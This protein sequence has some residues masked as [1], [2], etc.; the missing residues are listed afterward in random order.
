[1]K[2]YNKITAYTDG[3]SRGNPGPSAIGI[4]I[5][6]MGD[7]K[8]YCQSIGIATNNIAEYK[9]VIFALKKIRSLVGKNNLKDVEV[10]IKIDSELVVKQLNAE[11]RV[12]NEDMKVLFMD[13]W[14]LKFDFSK[15]KFTHIF[16]EENTKADALVNKC[17]DEEG[18]K[19]F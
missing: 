7:T 19:L 4:A 3:G 8:E 14:N 16:R 5:E 18:S 17:L 6:G 9:A 1:M 2:D 15:L 13:I 10:E 12:E 11:Y